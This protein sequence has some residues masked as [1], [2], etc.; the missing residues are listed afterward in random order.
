MSRFWG[1][2][3]RKC[4]NL[5]EKPVVKL[6]HHSADSFG[7]AH[8]ISNPQ[9]K[10]LARH[11]ELYVHPTRFFMAQNMPNLEPAI[12]AELAPKN[13]HWNLNRAEKIIHE[14]YLLPPEWEFKIYTYFCNCAY[15]GEM[16]LSCCL[17]M[18]NSFFP[19]DV[20]LPDKSAYW[21]LLSGN[22]QL[23]ER[24]NLDNYSNYQHNHKCTLKFLPFVVGER[25]FRFFILPYP[26]KI[27]L[28][29][30]A[31]KKALNQIQPL[32]P[33]LRGILTRIHS[34]I[35]MSDIR[36]ALISQDLYEE[37]QSLSEPIEKMEAQI[38]AVLAPFTRKFSHVYKD[39]KGSKITLP[40]SGFHTAFIN[41]PKF[42]DYRFFFEQ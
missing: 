1:E 38:Q 9:I 13:E 40:F 31:F 3:L 34:L 21:G 23:G 12:L 18:K 33:L 41:G 6:S 32:L 28:G 26:E 42:P 30:G 24:I 19:P 4:V 36:C 11:D 29:I 16:Y 20:H 8:I 39:M 5:P 37:G 35:K 7:L 15:G 22:L 27:A 2:T 17:Q 10:S 14:R 25:Q